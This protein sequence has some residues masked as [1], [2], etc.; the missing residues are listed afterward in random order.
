MAHSQEVSRPGGV[1][2][3]VIEHDGETYEARKETYQVEVDGELEEVEQYR[4]PDEV[5]D[6]EI[7][8]E[9]AEEIDRVNGVDDDEDDVDDDQEDGPDRDPETG[10]FVSDDE[11]GSE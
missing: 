10:E 1:Q 6:E 9:V 5:P 2:Y 11:E 4:M 8:V 3:F 7:P